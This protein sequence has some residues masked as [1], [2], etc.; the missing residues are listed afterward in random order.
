MGTRLLSEYLIKKHH[1]QLRYV[2]VH[3]SGKNQ[4]TLYAW[5]DDLQLPERD[6][7]TLKR[8]VSGYLPPHV[9]FQIKAYSMVQA[10]GVPKEYDLPESIVRTAMKRELDQYGIV[11]S[12]NTMLDSGGMAFSRYDFNSGTLYFNIHM[13]TV[14]MD[15]EKELIRMYLSEIIPLGSKCN[16][17]F[18]HSLAAR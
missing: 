15:I 18:E 13:T 2:R 10:D 17:Q 3:T 6:V 5:N 4:A 8:F 7:D 14:L 9:C 12:I 11:A 16:V 1:P